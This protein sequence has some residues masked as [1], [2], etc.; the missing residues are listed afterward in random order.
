M[1]DWASVELRLS[2]DCCLGDEWFTGLD[3]L[4]GEDGRLEPMSARVSLALV[5]LQLSLVGE[6]KSLMATESSL[7]LGES[8]MTVSGSSWGR[9]CLLE[10]RRLRAGRRNRKNLP[11]P[12]GGITNDKREDSYCL[13][14]D[15]C[16]VC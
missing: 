13:H 9:D 4:M 15:Y 11:L 10:P 8:I 6:R 1:V 14:A 2:H 5:G 12:D 3:T 7:S 16:T